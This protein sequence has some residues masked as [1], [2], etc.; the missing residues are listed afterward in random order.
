M[1]FFK[2][3]ITEFMAFLPIYN[4]FHPIMKKST[5]DIQEIDGDLQKLVDDMFETMYT[6]D[7]IGLAANQVGVSKSLVVIDTSAATKKNDPKYVLINPQILETS[8]ET[9][10]YQEGCLSVPKFFEDVIRPKKVKVRYWDLKGKEFNIE[11]DDTLARV[12]QHEIDHLNGILF[13][14]RLTPLRRTLSKSKL[15]RIRKRQTKP[16]Y[17]MVYE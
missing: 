13:Y 1:L 6:A 17:E 12:M 16:D 15:N 10:D 9:N 8:E 5:E 14:E 4:C 3:K 2:S 11:A 7:G